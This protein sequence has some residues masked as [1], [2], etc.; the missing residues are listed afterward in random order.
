MAMSWTWVS[1]AFDGDDVSGV[2]I[3]HSGRF[4]DG[5]LME[6]AGCETQAKNTAYIA[7]NING[8]TCPV[9]SAPAG[10][11]ESLDPGFR[12]GTHESHEKAR[13]E[14]KLGAM[15]TPPAGRGALHPQLF[16]FRELWCISWFLTSFPGCCEGSEHEPAAAGNPKPTTTG[17]SLVEKV[18]S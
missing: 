17:S 4:S 2:K 14:R 1:R 12:N 7:Q 15:R 16:E 11:W 3:A 10:R 9:K 13:N 18:S 5:D 6:K 8:A